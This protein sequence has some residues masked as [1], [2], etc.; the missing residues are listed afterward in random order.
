M[1]EEAHEAHFGGA[2]RV[3]AVVAG[4]VDHQRARGARRSVGAERDLVEQPR[5]HGTAAAGL[6]I[7]VEHLGLDLARRR[8]QREQRSPLTRYDVGKLEPAIGDLGEVVIEPLRQRRVEIGDAALGV[9]GEETRRRV[10]EIIDGVLQ[11]L[12]HV[13][14]A[15]ELAG[16]VGNRPYRH[17]LLAL[18]FT[19][20]AHAHAQP[21]AGLALVAADPDLLLQA[22]AF[23]RRLEQPVDGL[24]NAGI[25]HEHAFDRPHVVDVGGRDEIE[26]GDIGVD[27]AAGRVGDHDGIGRA[28]DQVLDQGAGGIPAGGAQHAGRQR[29]QQKH[30]DH[31][32][33]G[34]ER[35]DVWLGLGA[36]DQH[37][38]DARA[39]QRHRD[40]QN[41]ADAAAVLAGAGAVDRCPFARRL[42]RHDGGHLLPTAAVSCVASHVALINVSAMAVG[43]LSPTGR[44]SHRVCGAVFESQPLPVYQR[45]V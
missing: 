37:Q 26:I 11:F 1:L 41:E 5:R 22:T 38:A 45:I 6:Q 10:I 30:P 28:I 33:H 20:R 19:E 42:L 17:P 13:L 9:G 44:G 23:A 35:K 40:Q 14:L 12:K 39:D 15:L 2:Q 8:R 32:Q 24:R 29:E 31:R 18:A 36:A 43:S 21:A 7:D 34:Q 25:A 3:V 27:H 16:D 4:A